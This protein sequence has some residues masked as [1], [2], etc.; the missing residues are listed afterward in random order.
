[1]RKRLAIDERRLYAN[2]VKLG[3]GA[4]CHGEI[5]GLIA[6]NRPKPTC[7]SCRQPLSKK[8]RRLKSTICHDC[9]K[10]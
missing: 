5:H 3:F 1:M 2:A 9:A 7:S 6:R 8:R 10:A 4:L